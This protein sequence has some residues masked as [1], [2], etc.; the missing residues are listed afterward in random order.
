LSPAK[1]LL[2]VNEQQHSGVMRLRGDVGKATIWFTGGELV[3]ATSGNLQGVQAVFRAMRFAKGSYVVEFGEP[4]RAVRIDAPLES[5]VTE[6]TR[7]ADQCRLLVKML[8]PLGQLLTVNSERLGPL[9]EEQRQLVQLFDPHCSI[10]EALDLSEAGELETM[11]LLEQLVETGTLEPASGKPAYS[12]DEVTAEIDLPTLEA[13]QAEKALRVEKARQARKA[14]QVKKAREAQKALEAQ[15]VEKPK[16]RVR[17][18]PPQHAADDEDTAVK[19]IPRRSSVP[20]GPIASTRPSSPMPERPRMP[21]HEPDEETT[22]V[23]DRPFAREQLL[24]DPETVDVV[25]EDDEPTPLG[26]RVSPAPEPFDERATVDV[27]AAL[28]A[29]AALD[30]M[31]TPAL[32]SSVVPSLSSIPPPPKRQWGTWLGVL[33]LLGVAGAAYQYRAQLEQWM[34]ST[35]APTG[36]SPVARPAST[37]TVAATTLG[38]A[39]G[40]VLVKG[41]Q[42]EMGSSLNKGVLQAAYPP[43]SVDVADVCMDRTEVTL[44][45]YAECASSGGCSKASREASWPRARRQSHSAWKKSLQ[46]HSEQCNGGKVGRRNHPVNCVSWKQ[47]DAFCRW[48]KARLPTEAEWE[49]AARGSGA[50]AQPW[51]AEPPDA[52]RMNGCGVECPRWHKRA[53]LA[54]E[55]DGVLYEVDD[56]YSDTAPVGSFQKGATPEGLLDMNGNVSELVA[57]PFRAYAKPD[58]GTAPEPDPTRRVIRGPAFDNEVAEF[59]VP[60][61]RRALPVDARTPNVGFRC[62]TDPKP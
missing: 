8:P 56:G 42:L 19:A 61:L 43:H 48:R 57:E 62:A 24:S 25:I 37:P 55:I 60:A 33:V 27:P 10:D 35:P 18:R 39:E 51:G 26:Q 36:V 16:V 40:A 4:E 20:A 58:G 44:A 3:D 31:A 46:R 17:V 1:L 7:R 9:D 13:Q 54:N 12:P 5:L 52:E 23:K 34:A 11:M 21:R 50:R 45:A 6:G 15:S 14:Q 47:A 38:C 28:D 59:S 2:Q 41:G 29:T 32:R 49:L 22:A 30:E 53:G